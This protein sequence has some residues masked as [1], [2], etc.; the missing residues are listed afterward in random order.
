VEKQ[1]GILHKYWSCLETS[2]SKQLSC[3]IAFCRV[4]ESPCPKN[5]R[6][7]QEPMRLLN[8]STV[9]RWLLSVT[10]NSGFA[11]TGR[12]AAVRRFPV[13]Y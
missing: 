11:K 7:V 5:A 1:A 2:A 10:G 4:G 13:L 3:K 6:L 9:S 8:K 12:N